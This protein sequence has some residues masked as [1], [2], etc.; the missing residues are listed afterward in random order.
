MSWLVMAGIIIVG[1]FF[2]GS[3]LLVRNRPEDM[4]QLPDGDPPGFGEDVRELDRGKSEGE[5]PAKW[6]MKD[7]LRM[8]TTWLIAA[9]TVCYAVALGTTGTHQ[10]AYIRDIGFNPLIAATTLSIV[11]GIAI[12]GSLGF[13]TLAI[14][15]DIRYLASGAFGFQLIALIILM[16]TENLTL[17]YLYT[18]LYGIGNGA[19]LVAMPTFIGACY[20]RGLYSRVMGIISPFQVVSQAAAATIAGAIFDT[21]N[22]YIPAFIL[23]TVFSLVGLIC[24]LLVR[25]S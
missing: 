10:V 19:L 25:K 23:I 13:G 1:A 11:S 6:Q 12:V 15:I 20:D 9:I 17:I 14:R 22:S 8:P 18:I 5:R 4:N 2:I 24:V 3:L 7:I 21:A 16:T